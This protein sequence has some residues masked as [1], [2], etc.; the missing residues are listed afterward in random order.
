MH[1]RA[2]LFIII[3]VLV[4]AVVLGCVI[5]RFTRLDVSLSA[6]KIDANGEILGTYDIFLHGNYLKYITGKT[7][8]DVSV[9]AFDHL[10]QF[11]PVR[12]GRNKIDVEIQSWPGDETLYVHYSAWDMEQDR[13]VLVK[14][15]FS[16]D[17]DRWML[18]D[19]SDQVYYLGSV[20]GT[21]TVQ[22]LLTYFG[23]SVD[24]A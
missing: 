11:I 24:C 1:K 4:T 2:M 7:A 8:L 21:Y 12:N 18:T 20:S 17:M 9:S 3:A 15:C 22:E 19:M 14:I 10:E 16:P 23:I 5:P 6:S 13:S